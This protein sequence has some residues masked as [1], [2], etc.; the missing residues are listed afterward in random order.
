MSSSLITFDALCLPFFFNGTDFEDESLCVSEE[1]RCVRFEGDA[2][3]SL[4][5][6]NALALDVEAMV[7]RRGDGL[8]SGSR[9]IAFVLFV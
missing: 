3:L 9:R 6:T 4:L 1:G 5:I 7:G 8:R 2:D